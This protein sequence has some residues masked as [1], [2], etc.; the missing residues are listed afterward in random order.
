MDTTKNQ[1]V[2]GAAGGNEQTPAPSATPTDKAPK[3]EFKDGAILVDGKKMVKES[4]LMAAKQSLETQLQRQ[5]EAHVQAIDTAKLELSDAQKQV[6]TLNAEL[7]KAKE[8]SKTGA[9]SNED[10]ARVKADLAT[11]KSGLESANSKILELRI[12]NIVVQSGGSVTAEQLK[13]KTVEQLDSFEEALKAFLKSSGGGPGKYALGGLGGGT[14][15]QLPIDRAKEVL[16]A[17]PMRG[18]RNEPAQK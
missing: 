9:A 6:A 1:E 13:G 12:A 10:V 15:A 18:T 2:A 16:A 7:T 8:A 5:Q 11:A 3:V 17:T 14:T 4:D